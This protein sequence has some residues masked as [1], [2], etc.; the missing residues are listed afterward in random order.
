[1]I[2]TNNI[3]T[4]SRLCMSSA[5]AGYKLTLGADAP[6]ACYEDIA[7]ADC[8]FIAGA[9]M[10]YAHPVLFRR[11]EDAKAANPALRIVV[12]DPRRTIPRLRRTCFCRF[13][14]DRHRPLQRHAARDAVG[15]PVRH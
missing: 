11:I 12:V 5:V 8:L 15:R 14:P 6:P 10:A 9:N 1:L 13:C 4:N 7:R 2:G 3:D